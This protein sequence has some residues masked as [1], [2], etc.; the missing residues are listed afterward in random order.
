LGL[1]LYLLGACFLFHRPFLDN[2]VKR[3]GITLNENSLNIL[4]DIGTVERNYDSRAAAI[5]IFQNKS[6]I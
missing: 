4:A 3:I 1:F 6:S 2:E 5:S